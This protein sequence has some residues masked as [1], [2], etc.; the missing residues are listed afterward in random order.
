VAGPDAVAAYAVLYFIVAEVQADVQHEA[1]R[2]CDALPAGG[3]VLAV[4]GGRFGG[5]VG[6]SSGQD[7]WVPG[8]MCWFFAGAA[9][10]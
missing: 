6:C 4:D 9:Q 2:L 10:D 8:G 3:S 7:W 5:D 1:S